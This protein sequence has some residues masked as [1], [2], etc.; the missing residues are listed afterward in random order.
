MDEQANKPIT[1]SKTFWANVTIIIAAIIAM[2]SNQM[3]PDAVVSL[4]AI[5][6]LEVTAEKIAG[7]VAIVVPV[8]NI[9]LRLVTDQ[10]LDLS[11][12]VKE[13]DAGTNTNPS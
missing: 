10:P 7:T 12:I 8:L 9:G 4:S 2:A 13:V 6:G 1:A 3:F 5:F 11:W